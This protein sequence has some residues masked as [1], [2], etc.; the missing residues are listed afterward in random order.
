[1]QKFKTI[2]DLC[3]I[4][5]GTIASGC[6]KA[7]TTIIIILLVFFCLPSNSEIYK[8]KDANGVLQYS[9]IKP[10]NT[11]VETFEIQSYQTVTIVDGV[12]DSQLVDEN[13]KKRTYLSR[14][15]KVIMYSTQWCG[16]C[17]Q[18]K[19]YF[20]KNKIAFKEYDIEKSESAKK[21]YKKLGATGVPVILVGKK[22]MNGFS[23]ERF[24]SIYK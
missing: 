17:K 4:F 2:G 23:V 15:K 3:S 10:E 20:R 9:D 7:S 6:V 22:R 21:R 1:M 16:Y 14:P 12:E 8:W 13:P 5:T 19:R 11:A 24:N 18:A